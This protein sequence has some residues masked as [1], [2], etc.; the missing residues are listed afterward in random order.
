LFIYYNSRVKAAQQK[1]IPANRIADKGCS[2]NMSVSTLKELGT[3]LEDIWP[4]DL[5]AIDIR[6]SDFA[7]QK[8]KDEL[9][10]LDWKPMP[11]KIDLNDMKLCL[12][13]GFPF[14]FGLV[15]FESFRKQKD[16]RIE[17]PKPGDDPARHHGRSVLFLKR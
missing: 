9:I 3:C 1:N 16:G 5:K 7:Y 6:P 8:A 4:Y 2:I 12:A 10:A 14:V 15:L 11:V 17:M 13:K